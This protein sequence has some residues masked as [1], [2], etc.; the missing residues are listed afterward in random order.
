M[1]KKSRIFAQQNPA[2]NGDQYLLGRQGIDF[3]MTRQQ[4]RDNSHM[5]IGE[6]I[7]STSSLSMFVCVFRVCV[8]LL[9]HAHV[10]TI[11][12]YLFFAYWLQKDPLLPDILKITP[13]V[14]PFNPKKHLGQHKKQHTG[15]QNYLQALLQTLLRDRY[16]NGDLP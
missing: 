12:C 10:R 6:D 16:G 15:T 8:C 1:I 2:E 9:A 11:I 13:G 4:H 3:M 7:Y 5:N 14:A